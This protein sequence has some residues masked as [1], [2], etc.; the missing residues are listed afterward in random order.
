MPFTTAKTRIQNPHVDSVSRYVRR[1]PE[2]IERDRVGIS[3]EIEAHSQDARFVVHPLCGIEPIDV[4]QKVIE[5]IAH[6]L[7]KSRG[8]NDLLN[9]LEAERLFNQAMRNES[10]ENSAVSRSTARRSALRHQNL[11]GRSAIA[12]YV[13]DN[14]GNNASS[15][16]HSQRS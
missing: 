1:N 8:G 3:P 4:T 2:E 15:L 13:V 16:A 12:G 14:E 6:E 7:W 5:A 9:W 10:V 11:R